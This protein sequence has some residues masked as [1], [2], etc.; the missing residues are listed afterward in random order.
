MTSI[1]SLS[2]PSPR[3]QLLP[4]PG[5]SLRDTGKSGSFDTLF[6]EKTAPQPE[7][8]DADSSAAQDDRPLDG[9]EQSIDED[10]VDSSEDG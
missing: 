5:Q 9:D 2:S 8:A 3:T 10:S 4:M 1:S 7:L 6:A